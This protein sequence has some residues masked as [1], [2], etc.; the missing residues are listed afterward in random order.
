MP[1][2]YMLIGIPGSGK[3]T[4]IKNQNFNTDD[5]VI[6]ST[7]N[8]IEE[9]AASKGMTYSDVFQDEIK[10]ATAEMNN[11]LKNAIAQK[12]NIVWDQTNL[13]VKTRR[14]KLAQ[15]PDEYQKIAV[16][17]STPTKE[18]L[19]IRLDNR[20]GKIIP[21]NI[22]MGMISQLDPPSKLEGWDEI[23]TNSNIEK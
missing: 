10:S 7:D 12:K 14:S 8:I 18:E 22:L 1:T 19:K 13:T 2:L 3:T 11:N 4:W 17:L 16:L 23:W 9:R 5:T 15:I 21:N 20:P 6:V